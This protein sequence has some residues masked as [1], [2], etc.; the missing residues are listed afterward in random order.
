M[1]TRI[2]IVQ[3]DHEQDLETTLDRATQALRRKEVVIVGIAREYQWHAVNRAAILLR[4]ESERSRALD[5]L[6]QVGIRAS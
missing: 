3:S 4:D 2:G 6:A 5:V 1:T